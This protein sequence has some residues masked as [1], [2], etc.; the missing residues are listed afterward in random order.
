M[1]IGDTAVLN[2]DMPYGSNAEQEHKKGAT[3]SIL[4]TQD[5][6]GS[7]GGQLVY[8]EFTSGPGL[9]VRTWLHTKFFEQGDK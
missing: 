8:A 5:H 9:G 2:I 4:N 6:G 3:V 1:K 7:S